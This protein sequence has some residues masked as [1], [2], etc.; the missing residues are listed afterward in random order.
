MND[1]FTKCPLHYRESKS[2]IFFSVRNEINSAPTYSFS[3]SKAESDQHT[4]F[5]IK[6]EKFLFESACLI[7]IEFGRL[8]WVSNVASGY[9]TECKSGFSANKKP[10]YGRQR[11]VWKATKV[12]LL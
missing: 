11:R 6:Q 5:Q 1:D 8:H 4:E 12:G 2:N 9:V 7:Y 10:K 3:M